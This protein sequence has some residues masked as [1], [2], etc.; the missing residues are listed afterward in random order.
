[1][2]GWGLVIGTVAI[3]GFPPFGVFMSEF[4]VLTATMKSAPWLTL[5]LLVGLGIAFAG[6]F[7][8]IHPMVYGEPPEGQKPVEANM[9]PVMLHLVIVLWLGL[10]IPASCR[11]GSSRPPC[12]SPELTA[13]TR[14]T[15]LTP[16]LARLA[17]EGI[18][19]QE[20]QVAGLAPARVIRLSA[21][22]WG[23]LAQQARQQNC[24]W[25]ACWAKTRAND[26]VVHAA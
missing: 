9:L 13:M 22:N 12:S 19:H 2:I 4:L 7:R 5:P 21:E 15:W 6:L 11:S 10:A 20:E 16:F 25:L 18:V 26:I 23:Q 14:M 24:R 3:A 1:M 17:Q 8:H